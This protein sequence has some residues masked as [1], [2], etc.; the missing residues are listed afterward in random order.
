MQRRTIQHT[1]FSGVNCQVFINA[2][3]IILKEIFTKK[4]TISVFCV[5]NFLC[6]GGLTRPHHRFKWPSPSARKNLKPR[7]NAQKAVGKIVAIFCS[8]Q[9]SGQLAVCVCLRR[10]VSVETQG[11]AAPIFGSFFALK[12][13]LKANGH[14]KKV[15]CETIKLV[16]SAN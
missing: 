6:V 15:L 16:R 3:D 13:K 5:K 9:S 2:Q 8:T 12:S 7:F 14:L 4:F 10:G 11:T 1:C